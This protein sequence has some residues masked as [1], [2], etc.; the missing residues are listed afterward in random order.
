[1]ELHFKQ[2]YKLLMVKKVDYQQ[3]LKIKEKLRSRVDVQV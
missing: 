3:L 2:I 1:M